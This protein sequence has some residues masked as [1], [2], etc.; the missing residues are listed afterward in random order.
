M[1]RNLLFLMF[2]LFG[3]FANAQTSVLDIEGLAVTPEATATKFYFLKNVGTGLY[4]SYGGEWSTHCIETNAAHPI[5]LE[6]QTIDGVSYVAIGSLLG[7][8]DSNTLWMDWSKATSKWKLVKAQ[9]YTNQYYI[10]GDGDR[11]LT[12]VGHSAGLLTLKA[13]EA[14]K[15]GLS[16][17]YQRW[18]FL[19]EEEMHNR[20]P[21][22]TAENPLDVTPFIKAS[23]FDK[24]DG[25]GTAAY[26][27]TGANPQMQYPKVWGTEP[28]YNNNWTNYV[29]N[30][31][32]IWDCGFNEWNPLTYNWIGVINGPDAALDVTQSVQLKAGTYY[33]SFEGFCNRYYKKVEQE[34]RWG[35][36]YGDPKITETQ[37]MDMNASVTVNGKEY[38]LANARFAT[39]A[40]ADNFAGIAIAMRDADTY[41]QEDVFYL[42]S[43]ATVEFKISKKTT[44]TGASGYVRDAPG[45]ILGWRTVTETWNYSRIY[46]DEFVLQY[47]GPEKST[48]VDHS[49]LYVLYLE[50]NIEEYKEFFNEEGD[51][52]FEELLADLDLD[53][54][55]TKAEYYAAIAKVEAAYVH[56]L[57]YHTKEN[58]LDNP[59]GDFTGAII[60]NS[61]EMGDLTGWETPDGLG[62]DSRVVENSN[63]TYTTNGVD[64]Y[65]LFNT[66]DGNAKGYKLRQVVDG[67]PKG[68]YLLKVLVTSDKDYEVIATVNKVS[69]SHVV[70]GDK[71]AFEE[72]EVEF[73]VGDNGVADISVVGSGWYKCDNFRLYYIPGLELKESATALGYKVNDYY[74]TVSIDR[75]IPYSNWST[76]VVPF[77]MDVPY[78]WD[79]RE[80]TKSFYNTDK[81]GDECLNLHFSKVAEIEAGVP[82]LVRQTRGSNM[83]LPVTQDVT[84][85]IAAPKTIDTDC[86]VF[87]GTFIKGEIPAG[88]YYLSGNKFYKTTSPV[89]TKGFRA[90]FVPKD[91]NVKMLSFSFDEEGE[92]TD[93]EDVQGATEEPVVVAV[94]GIDGTLR[95]EMQKGLNI[96]KMSNGTVK[97]VLLP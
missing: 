33:F 57:A 96:V 30:S 24:A 50:A 1:K 86:A 85:A 23:A 34:E 7:Y 45:A 71:G 13:N 81:N 27:A 83:T 53:A 80:F 36:P 44:G 63:G 18:V 47:Y 46:I 32:S 19:T 54:I 56:A 21:D 37:G 90:W 93:I 25:R 68:K 26:D 14:D 74:S 38:T 75:T 20:M 51:A 39:Q 62:G 10:V 88:A 15:T 55:N 9:G 97:K 87:T 22:A 65:F 52:K 58:A 78:G 3:L 2:A 29:A 89:A 35:S 11:V 84:F 72:V 77:D 12:S 40:E 8:L 69:T 70:T 92:A 49:N 91:A 5:A 61:F 95:T 73:N 42:A 28:V 43:D 64:G 17:A 16:K 48:T 67:L 31:Q 94:Y 41:K 4:V 60:N 82:Y 76:L 66:W 59:G 6:T 79:V